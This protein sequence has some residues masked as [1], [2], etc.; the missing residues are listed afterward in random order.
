[1]SEDQWYWVRDS[2]TRVDTEKVVQAAVVVNWAAESVKSAWLGIGATYN[3]LGIREGHSSTASTAVASL[4][5]EREVLLSQI[6]ALRAELRP[7]LSLL[8]GDLAEHAEWLSVAALVYASA[9]ADASAYFQY[10]EAPTAIDCGRAAAVGLG[11]LALTA[12]AMIGAMGAY[13]EGQPVQTTAMQA[14]NQLRYLDSTRS[15]GSTARIA[16]FLS[17]VWFAAGQFALTPSTG[18]VVVGEGRA[19]WGSAQHDRSSAQVIQ[20]GAFDLE[21]REAR[22]AAPS[23]MVAGSQG[24]MPS[25]FSAW[26]STKHPVG[27]T[28]TLALRA[29]NRSP[30]CTLLTNPPMTASA[31]LYS[32]EDIPRVDQIGEIQILRHDRPDRPKSSWSVV[33]RGTQEW[34]PGSANPQDL[35]S[36]FH[37]VAGQISDQHVAVLAAMDMAGIRPGDAIEFVGHSQGGAVALSLAASERV[38]SRFNVVSVLTAGGPVGS[39]PDPSIR[40]LALENTADI[41]P[42]LDGRASSTVGNHVVVHFDRSGYEAPPKVGAHGMSTYAEAAKAL[43]ERAATS[44]ELSAFRKWEEARVESL[45]LGAAG[46]TTTSMVFASRRTLGK[47]DIPQPPETEGERKRRQP[48]GAD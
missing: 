19:A 12:P 32:L 33:I 44:E 47:V 8:Q 34:F 13:A 24:L 10:C 28:A 20:L 37:E 9:D 5:E 15:T 1:M 30:S 21:H 14:E 36:N 46:V 35:L 48:A 3:W 2:T 45:G 25:S 17:K 16:S 26:K 22:G 40:V 6:R 29:M 43:R 11:G 41:V 31:L 23:V 27:L 4:L 39:V 42:S 7:A 38:T 18:V